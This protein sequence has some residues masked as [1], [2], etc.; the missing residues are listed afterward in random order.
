MHLP[1]PPS[2]RKIDRRTFLS[3]GLLAAGGVAFYSGEIARHKIEVLERELR[4]PHLPEAFDGLRMVQI[5]DLHMDEYTEESF[6]RHVVDTIN[7]LN[8][9]VVALTGDFVST[10]PL[11]KKYAVGAA[12]RCAEILAGL[13]CP[14]KFAV[15]GNHDVNTNPREVTH[16]LTGHGIPVLN[17]S[18]AALERGQSRLWMAGMIDLSDG[19]PRPELAIPASIRFQ[20]EEPVILLC[21]SPDFADQLLARPVGQAVSLMLS[22]HTHGGQIRV[23]PFGPL[24][25]PPGGRKYVHGLFSLGTMQLYVNRG[26]GAVGLPFRFDCPPEITVMT[27]KAGTRG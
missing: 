24:V 6:L 10:G 9:D 14:Q 2:L 12:W 27:L 22:G 25:L 23:P 1:L 21:H 17:N 16:A 5:S 7:Q 26:I 11:G 20:P 4:L 18:H 19:K 15:L 13:K 3:T 8:P